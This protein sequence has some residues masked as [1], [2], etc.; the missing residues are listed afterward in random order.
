MAP[1]DDNWN[2]YR[3]HVV[4]SL[5]KTGDRL[6]SID[7]RLRSIERDLAVI[8]TKIYVA[9]GT[10]AIIFSAIATIFFQLVASP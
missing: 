1:K 8:R 2:E 10:A 9:A 4:N 7:E 3:R 6:D 5:S